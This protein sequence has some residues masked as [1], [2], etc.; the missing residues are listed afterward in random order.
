MDWTAKF[1]KIDPLISGWMDRHGTLLLRFSLAVVFI[2]FGA[3]KPLGVS[4]AEEL[5]KRT[6]YWFSP[7]LFVPI[8]GLWEVA[9]GV[10]LLFRPLLRVALLLLFLQMPGTVLPLI[11]L[12]DVCFTQFPFGLTLE[13]QYIIKN[14]ILISAAIVVGGTVRMKADGGRWM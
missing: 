12:P 4:P 9:I 10:G 14:L 7:D 3:L 5:V 13:G 2:W 6:V 8:L 1:E 11:L